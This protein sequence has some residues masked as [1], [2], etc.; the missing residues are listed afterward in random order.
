MRIHL[1]VVELRLEM[2]LME[3]T[4]EGSRVVSDVL[5]TPDGSETRYF[6]TSMF[7]NES[8]NCTFSTSF[9]FILIIILFIFSVFSTS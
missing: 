4:E 9:L 2:G 3:Y 5:R 7:S 1:G 8:A 6:F